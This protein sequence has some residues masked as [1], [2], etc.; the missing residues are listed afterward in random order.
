M[1][2]AFFFF[3]I[4]N[5]Q[6]M[7]P[8]MIDLLKK[9]EDVWICIFD[10][11]YKKKQFHY[12]ENCE[13]INFMNSILVSTSIKGNYKIDIYRDEDEKIY[14]SHYVKNK[15]EFIFIQDVHH[16]YP[17]WLPNTGKSKLIYFPWGKDGI[18]NLQKSHIDKS[19]IVL[20][21]LRHREDEEYFEQKTGINS[22]YFGRIW[23]DY[24]KLSKEINN[25][26]FNKSFDQFKKVCFIP[27]SWIADQKSGSSI[28]WSND[29]IKIVNDVLAHLRAREYYTIVKKREKGYPFDKENG[30]TNYISVKPNLII[31]KDLYFPS[32]LCYLPI[33][34]DLT[35]LVGYKTQGALE[36][37]RYCEENY[38][39]FF[40][41]KSIESL[42]KKLCKSR[43]NKLILNKN[44]ISNK[45]N[46]YINENLC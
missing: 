6:D 23:D 26:T 20:N 1:K 15:P 3:G 2:N 7:L 45:I 38:L 30:F 41:C 28:K 29:N 12:Y 46:E 10:V 27:E 11:V 4:T 36:L 9:G 25:L 13:L 37:Q 18:S 19:N 42:E 5:F 17:L 40:H 8:P 22:I 24:I 43:K 14:K 39:N 33:I 35:L 32:S 16:K 44:N 31:E 21:V 34:S